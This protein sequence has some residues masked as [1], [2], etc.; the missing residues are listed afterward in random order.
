MLTAVRHEHFQ[1]PKIEAAP[2][3]TVT[4]NGPVVRA[5][6]FEMGGGFTETSL[7]RGIS[8]PLGHA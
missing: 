7:K 5:D 4:S 1:Q 3:S 8:S 6:N 2:A